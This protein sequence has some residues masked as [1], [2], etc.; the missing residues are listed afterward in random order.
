MAQDIKEIQKKVIEV[1]ADKSCKEQDK[2]YAGSSLIADLGMDSLDAIETI[3]EF[4]EQYGIEIPDD[5]IRAFKIV[6]DIVDYLAN[7]LTMA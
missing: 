1:L 6:Q 3:F 4:E 2:I 5:H 7:R